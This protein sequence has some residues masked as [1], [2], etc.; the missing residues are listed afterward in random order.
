MTADDEHATRRERNERMLAAWKAGMPLTRIAQENGLSLS[1]T[2][3]LLRELGITQSKIRQGVKRK[4]L[5]V[6]AIVRQYENGATMKALANYHKASYATIRR[7]LLREKVAIRPHGGQ[8]AKEQSP[9]LNKR[10]RGSRAGEFTYDWSG[11]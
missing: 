7:L 6:N 3:R 9:L 8:N 1:W 5:P 4:D 11:R 2:G 10:S